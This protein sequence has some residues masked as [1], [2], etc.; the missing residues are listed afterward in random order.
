MTPLRALAALLFALAGVGVYVLTLGSGFLR[1]SGLPAFVPLFVATVASLRALRRPRRLAALLPA[2][3]TFALAGAFTYVFFVVARLPV[4]GG[5]E[6]LERAPAFTRPVEGE[7]P[8]VLEQQ[9]ARGPVL[10]VFY[11]GHW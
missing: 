6:A 4:A 8:F 2:L 11:R 10:L 1:E 3:L 5:F 9:L 7:P